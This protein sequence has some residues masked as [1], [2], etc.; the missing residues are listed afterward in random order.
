MVSHLVFYQLAVI[1][2]VWLCVMRLYVWPS[3]RIRRPTPAAPRVPRRQ[4]P[5]AP[6]PFAGRTTKPWCALGDQESAGLHASPPGRPAPRPPTTWHPRTVDPSAHVC[7]PTGGDYRGGGFGNLRAHGPPRG[8][9]WRQF[10]CRA[11]AGY[12]LEPPGTILHGTRGAVELSVR[13]LAGLAQ[14]LGMRATA[15]LCEVAPHTV[16]PWLVAAAEHLRAFSAACRGALHAGHLPLDALYAGGRDRKAGASR[17]AAAMQRR[18]RSPSWGWTA[19]APTS[20]LLVVGDGGSRPLAMAQRVGPQ[21]AQGLGPGGVPRVLS[22][23][24]KEY[25]TAR[26]AP[27]GAGRHP[28]RRQ[29]H[30]PRPKPRWMPRPELLSAPGVKASRRRRIGRV[31]HRGGGHQGAGAAA[32]VGVGLASQPSL[33][34]AAAPGHPPARGRARPSRPYALPG[35]SRLAASP[36]VGPELPSLCAAPCQLPPVAPPACAHERQ[37][38]GHGVAAVYT[39][40]GSGSDRSRRVTPRGPVLPGPPVAP[41]AESRSHGGGC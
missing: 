33:C 36:R 16:L 10:P 39:R 8:G 24:C 41:A 5:T 13:V 15:R 35:R 12:V 14:G 40:D 37:G 30:G 21:V 19:L 6:T 9:P 32:P 18:E 27:V 17:A 26:R 1:V 23:G 28:E 22:D 31:Q 29:A 20:K 11:Y 38:R 25:G 3:A 34:G 4:H 2:L 7:P